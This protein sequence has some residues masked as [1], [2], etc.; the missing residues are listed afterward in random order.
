MGTVRLRVAD[1]R[2]EGERDPSRRRFAR[3][4]LLIASLVLAVWIIGTCVGC[5]FSFGD[6]KAEGRAAEEDTLIVFSGE[7]HT[8]G[9]WASMKEGSSLKEAMVSQGFI[10]LSDARAAPRWLVDEVLELGGKKAAF[11]NPAIDI[12]GYVSEGERDEVLGRLMVEL[13]ERGWAVCGESS[14]EVVT[15]MKQEGVCRWLMAECA[16]QEGDTSVVLHIG[17][18]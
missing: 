15:L 5:A 7:T 18:S 8:K 4:L 1:P 12:V 13:S 17:R 9:I 16:E 3:A 6:A 14:A 11:S 10:D 2:C